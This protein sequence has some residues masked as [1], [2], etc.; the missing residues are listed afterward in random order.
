MVSCDTN[1]LFAASNPDDAHHQ[2]ALDFI[3]A[4]AADSQFVVAEQV[5]VELYCLL[6]NPV[7][8]R[9]PLTAGEAAMVI[10]TYRH[11][12]AWAVVDVPSDPSAMNAVWRKAATRGFARRRIHDVRLA[13]TLKY[14]GVDEFYTRNT[15]DF[16]D[17]GFRILSNPFD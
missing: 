1:I 8:Q 7:V 5:F 13:E 3:S 12:P 4:H 16:E 9:K 14:W 17:A 15:R 11:N 6:R 2:A 10:S